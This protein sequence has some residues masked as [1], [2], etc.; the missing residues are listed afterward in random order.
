MWFVVE[1][2]L[3]VVE[4]ELVVV[5]VELVVVE[6]G[7]VVVEM[8]LVVV[9]V[10]LVFVEMELVV[11]EMELCGCRGT[12]VVV[13]CCVSLGDPGPRGYVKAGGEISARSGERGS[14]AS[15]V[16]QGGFKYFCCP[17]R[18][19]ARSGC[20]TRGCSAVQVGP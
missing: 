15:S 11:V 7:L 19:V 5:E 1:M 17:R 12:Y 18:A 6:M 3:V 20:Q 10:E 16:G 9:E 4:M 13:V 14:G 2:E 8:E